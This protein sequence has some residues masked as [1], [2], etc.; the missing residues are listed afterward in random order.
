MGNFTHYSVYLSVFFSVCLSLRPYLPAF[1]A[2]LSIRLGAPCI[3]GKCSTTE[4]HPYPLCLFLSLSYWVAL[5]LMSS[6]AS[7]CLL[8][9]DQIELPWAETILFP[10]M[11]A[12][13]VAGLLVQGLELA[14]TPASPALSGLLQIVF[15]SHIT[16]AFHMAYHSSEW[17]REKLAVCLGHR[18]FLVTLA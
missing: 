10:R 11:L 2:L 7:L 1:F 6:C 8:A 9:G 17:L 4:L 16:G 15:Y 12:L 3:S 5:S 13:T 14:D 18:S